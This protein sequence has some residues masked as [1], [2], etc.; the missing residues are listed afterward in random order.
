MSAAAAGSGARRGGAV[1]YVSHR[2]GDLSILP[3]FF[4]YF[5]CRL[6]WTASGRNLFVRFRFIADL[7]T[8]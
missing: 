3:V 7:L 5:S 4:H 8:D 1:A 6:A 2:L